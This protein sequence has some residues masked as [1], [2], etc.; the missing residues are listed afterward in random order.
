M[1]L[2]KVSLAGVLILI[3]VGVFLVTRGPAPATP[4]P[5]GTFSFAVMGDAPYYW[6][7]ELRFRS[8]VQA[9][10]A[11]ELNSVISIGDIFWRP[12]TDAMYRRTLGHFNRIRHPVVY[13][14]GDNEWFDCWEPGSGAFMPRERLTRLRQIFFKSPTRSLGGRRI[15]LAS[16]HEFLENARWSDRE[17]VFATIHLIGSG[18]GVKPFPTRTAADDKEVTRRTEA[19]A[20]W[21]RETFAHA[22]NASAVVIALHGNPFD[23]KPE[24]REPY[25]PFLSTFAAEVRRFQRPVLVAHGDDH[26]YKVDHPLGLANLTRV[27]V[28]GSPDVGWVRVIVT[29]GARASFAFE[30]HLIPRWK[31]W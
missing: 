9:L 2:L 1:R 20:V 10:N 15:G 12:C 17:I 21:V 24:N 26:E 22:K 28:P 13:T 29:P 5:P 8:L 25:E 30:N 31:Y 7:E 16:Q 19:A 11:H 14:P 18:N 3:L 6:W 23:E 27:E 4:N